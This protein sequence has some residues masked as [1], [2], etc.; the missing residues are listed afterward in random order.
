MT[1]P[2][3]SVEDGAGISDRGSTPDGLTSEE[4]I[5]RFDHFGPNEIPIRRHAS[6]QRRFANQLLEPM[7][8]LLIVA[9]AVEAFGLGERLEAVAI[10]AIALNYGAQAELVEAARAL[11]VQAAA[12]GLDP[13][14]ID[15]DAIE[16]QLETRD[17]PPLDLLIRTSGEQRL[18]NFLL[19]Q[20][21]Y[22]ELLFVET[23][24]PDFGAD[25]L[26]AAVDAFGQR[27]R[28]YGGL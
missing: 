8:L 12:G 25:D 26:A 18:S 1:E 27:Q 28:R 22:A 24:W 6:W 15:A 4:A 17:L 2:H 20:A 13:T 14:A 5:A 9:S 7:S 10:L 23:L 11:A 16:T 19:W 21:A 3:P